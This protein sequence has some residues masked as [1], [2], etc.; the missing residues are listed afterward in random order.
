M[1]SLDTLVYG[2]PGL[3]VA[4]VFHEL[5]HGYM[6]NALGDPTPKVMGRLS[7][8]P[9]RHIDPVGFIMLWVFGFGWAKPVQVDPYNFANPRRDMALVAFAGPFTNFVLAFL[10][11]AILY[12]TGVESGAFHKMLL[13]AAWYNVGLG[14]FNLLPIPPLDGSKVLAGLLPA[15]RAAWL[16]AG[17]N[18]GWLILILLLATGLVHR[19]F[20]PMAEVV[21]R[22]INSLAA[23][24]QRAPGPGPGGTFF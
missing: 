15:D 19:I 14:V 13:V 24:F 20:L 11:L 6:A 5:G 1:L 10:A 16:E 17:E 22:L 12:A 23:L 18:Y 4:F 7:L 3:L 2:L 8:N 21:F 9:V